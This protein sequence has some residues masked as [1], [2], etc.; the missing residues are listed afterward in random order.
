[1]AKTQIRGTQVLDGT[2]SKDDIDII[3]PN[4]SL[5]TNAAAADF[6]ALAGTGADSGTGVVT[7]SINRANFDTYVR[8]STLTG[9]VP[10]NLPITG[11]DTFLGAFGKAQ[12]QISVLAPLNNPTFTG[13]PAAPTA[14]IDTNTTQL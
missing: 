4:K 3:T 13:V 12:G 11:T 7:L 10:T 2:I 8:A 1:M 9:I 14:P 6:I 5:I